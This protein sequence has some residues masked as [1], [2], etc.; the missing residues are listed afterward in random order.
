MTCGENI[1]DL[2]G[3]RLALRALK[4]QLGNDADL[5]IDGF[6]PVQ[7]FFLG[8]AFCWRQVGINFIFEKTFQ[9]FFLCAKF[10]ESD[11]ISLFF[12]SYS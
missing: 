1:A 10:V 11:S 12:H 6:T 9:K 7:R 2:G 8:W 5:A 4:A 3:L